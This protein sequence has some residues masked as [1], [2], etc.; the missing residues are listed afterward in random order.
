MAGQKARSAVFAAVTSRP[1]MSVFGCS[2]SCHGKE[3]TTQDCAEKKVCSE[4]E[5]EESG[6]FHKDAEKENPAGFAKKRNA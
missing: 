2:K 3:D 1:F 4:S 5:A 6:P